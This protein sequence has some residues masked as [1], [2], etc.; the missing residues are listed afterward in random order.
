MTT[1]QYYSRLLKPYRWKYVLAM[2]GVLVNTSDMLVPMFISTSIDAAYLKKPDA[3]YIIL[4]ALLWVVGIA[5]V[6]SF[7]FVASRYTLVGV[8]RHTAYDLR[9]T[10]YDKIL[11][12][13]DKFFVGM[14]TGEIMNRASSDVQ[15]I[16]MFLG[17]GGNLFPNAV[18]RTVLGTILMI[19]ISW[20][21]AIPILLFVPVLFFI[22]YLFGKK[23]FKLYK[24]LQDY[25]D[26]VVSR[27]QENYSGA[28]TVRS[29]NQGDHEKR[30]YKGMMDKYVQTIK[31]LNIMDALFWPV[32]NM[33][34]WMPILVILWYGGV[35]Y[36]K[37]QLTLGGLSAFI[38][39][40]SLMIWP[41]INLGWVTN[42]Y[43][44]SNASLKRIVEITEVVPDIKSPQN[45]YKPE[46]IE[47]NIELKDV[48]LSYGTNINSIDGISITI[49]KGQVVGV[50]GPVGSG[51]SSFGK[52]LL[53]VWD[54]D[55]GEV[56]IDGVDIKKWDLKMLRKSFGYVPQDNFLFS[57][58]IGENIAFAKPDA[59][60]EEIEK[61]AEMVQI[62]DEIEKFPQSFDT[63]VG[64]RGVTLSGGQ[65]QR[66]AIARALLL[67]PPMM[68]LDD[69]LSAVDTSTED[70]IID[71]LKPIIK[72]R[73]TIIIAHR[74]SAMRLADR[75]VV[76]DKGR[77]VED[78]THQ[79][80][81]T[82]GGYYA[83]LVEKQR[84]ATQIGQEGIDA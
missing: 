60:K 74:V 52:L 39:Y 73:T 83:D 14:S 10:I 3:K 8:S 56:S 58:S 25:S 27:V 13:P 24:I 21:L 22:E 46:T 5:V 57:T 20:K 30:M 63:V 65:R 9:N 33:A 66:V 26:K 47:G 6:R 31:P 81:M 41:I 80:L 62:K 55:S 40:V 44:R 35:L 67:D 12:L 4:S 54:S 43:Q 2:I 68:L 36:M 17:M 75:I 78:G 70:A 53:R 59:T 11:R 51:K 38:A 61:V 72:G 77:I 50:V 45:P 69:P 71:T 84:L 1:F 37:G 15:S 64:E 19:S 16:T 79:E 82:K 49:P 7:T 29:Y 23:I 18:L 76:L 42:L 48:K 32:L 34:S 28:R